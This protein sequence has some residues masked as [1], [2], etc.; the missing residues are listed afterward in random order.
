MLCHLKHSTHSSRRKS[1]HKTQAAEAPSS[2]SGSN[3]LDH[4]KC[5]KK[6]QQKTAAKPTTQ[7]TCITQLG[8]ITIN[9]Q[10]AE[11]QR[12]P[13]ASK[14]SVHP[15]WRKTSTHFRCAAA[16]TEQH[17]SSQYHAQKRSIRP[18]MRL[19]ESGPKASLQACGRLAV[20]KRTAT[21]EQTK[22][23]RSKPVF[24]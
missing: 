7:F 22:Q 5:I 23:G 21:Q 4:S 3:N 12:M 8:C 1:Q 20:T 6:K 13:S 14:F 9:F 19:H 10:Y 16:T 18:C 11:T 17:Q 2:H 24:S 15:S